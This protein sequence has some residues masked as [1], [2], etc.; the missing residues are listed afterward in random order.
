M[1][2]RRTPISVTVFEYAGLFSTDA[3]GKIRLREFHPYW[4]DM[5]T[6][7][8][9]PPHKLAVTVV[10]SPEADELTVAA[11]D[12]ID[13]ITAVFE[14]V[15]VT[16]LVTSCWFRVP[17]KTALAIKVICAPAAGV[18]VEGVIV[19]LVT[20]GQTVTVAV[21]V[22]APSVAVMVVTPGGE[23]MVAAALTCPLLV[24]TVAMV[25]SD[26]CQLLCEVTFEVLPSSN[27]PVAV[28]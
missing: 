8:L 18:V 16:R 10:E 17:E 1:W 7:G 23:A 4:T 11:P 5:V 20:T 13:G 9:V 12:E 19:M 21:L 26:D 22:K 24:P 14:I 27:V 28:I 25:V 2:S 6:G 3:S 15:H